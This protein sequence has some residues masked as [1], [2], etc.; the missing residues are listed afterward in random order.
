MASKASSSRRAAER[1]PAPSSGGRVLKRKEC[2]VHQRRGCVACSAK[3]GRAAAEK[4][5]E[6]PA[7]RP[8]R[9]VPA[10][11][12]RLALERRILELTSTVEQGV[13]D[14]RRLMEAMEREER[15][16]VD[17][18]RHAEETQSAMHRKL[19]AATQ[20]LHDIQEKK[21]W[22][23]E[24]FREEKLAGNHATAQVSALSA[25]VLEKEAQLLARDTRIT[26]LEQEGATLA[27]EA[28]KQSERAARAQQ[29]LLEKFADLERRLKESGTALQNSR[30]ALEESEAR[31]AEA[32]R[33]GEREKERATEVAIRLG[34]VEAA[35]AGARTSGDDR[36][37]YSERMLISKEESH[38]EE[39]RRL[40]GE[41][42]SHARTAHDASLKLEEVRSHARTAHD[43]S[44]KLEEVTMRLTDEA[45]HA[46]AGRK[47]AEAREE[48]ARA[49]SRDLERR[50]LALEREVEEARRRMEERGIDAHT[51]S[52][53]RD[54]ARC[55]ICRRAKCTWKASSARQW[56]YSS[57]PAP[58]RRPLPRSESLLS[59]PLPLS[60]NLPGEEGQE[61]EAGEE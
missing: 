27:K 50:A 10:D 6:R 11:V 1:A 41:V 19:A 54:Q 38:K 59:T 60:G 4:P 61:R 28:S 15:S 13:E 46:S 37:H 49:K 2:A 51:S 20:Q 40:E 35:L 52:I 22:L 16:V 47:E 36:S 17:T 48:A 44:L 3:A 33:V 34:T 39:V 7:E 55:G 5:E 45:R 31:A 56:T 12:G 58:T 32:L 24:A 43:A 25:Q 53:E 14:R 57:R 9:E 21:A 29:L 42:R 26:A 8:V 30:D 23:A 18:L